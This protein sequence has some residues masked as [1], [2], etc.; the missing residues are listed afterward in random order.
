M[1]VRQADTLSQSDYKREEKLELLAQTRQ[2]Y[3]EIIEK[4]ECIS[5]GD[6]K[7]SGKDLIDIGISPG[8]QIGVVLNAML[9]DVLDNPEH[10]TK[11]YLLEPE[12]LR[13]IFLKDQ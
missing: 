13:N 12:R 11:E 10:N 2:I 7:V 9:E 5:L 4:G 8:K 1:E 6:L 3:K